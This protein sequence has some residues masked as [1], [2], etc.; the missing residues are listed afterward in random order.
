MQEITTQVNLRDRK[1]FRHFTPVTIR[2]CDQ[3]SMDHVNNVAFTAYVEAARCDYILA[4]LG[5]FHYPTL[6]FVLARHTIEYL[7]E[8]HYPGTVDVG[9]RVLKVGTKSLTSGYGVFLGDTC[10]A[11]SICVNVFYDMQTRTSVAPPDDVRDA[12]R[13]ELA[14]AG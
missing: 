14:D 9:A 5:R 6:D 8:L 1:S 12:F 7:A 2:F 4:V 10:M 11:N 13:A 3:D